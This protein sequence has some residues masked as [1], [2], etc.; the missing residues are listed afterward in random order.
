MFFTS[1]QLLK[2]QKNVSV[3][4][5]LLYLVIITVLKVHNVG[6]WIILNWAHERRIT[7]HMLFFYQEQLLVG[8]DSTLY[9]LNIVGYFWRH[10]AVVWFQIRTAFNHWPKVKAKSLQKELLS[11][12]TNLAWKWME[13]PFSMRIHF[14]SLWMGPLAIKLCGYNLLMMSLQSALFYHNSHVKSHD[15]HWRNEPIFVSNS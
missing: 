3:W 5:P 7:H 15:P 11:V 6:R 9:E 12:Q 14:S 8:G 2:V 10:T 4:V 1:S 13:K